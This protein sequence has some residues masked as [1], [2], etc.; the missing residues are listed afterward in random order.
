MSDSRYKVKKKRR[1]KKSFLIFFFFIILIL[2]SSILFFSL[3]KSNGF[4]NLKNLLL[5]NIFQ[6]EEKVK[7]SPIL[8]KESVLDIFILRLP[9]QNLEFASS[10]QETENGDLKIFLKNTK[11]D[12]GY[13][14]LNKKD[15]GES[16][17]ITFASAIAQENFK[18]KIEKDLENLEYI[19]IRFGNKVFYKFRDGSVDIASQEDIKS[20]A[21]LATSTASSTSSN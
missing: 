9:S 15:D 17:W 16:L 13:I 20:E 10:S 1:F 7:T 21:P 2:L 5:E 4:Y 11:N 12:S 6:K 14:Y 19:D 8:V 3:R 18:A